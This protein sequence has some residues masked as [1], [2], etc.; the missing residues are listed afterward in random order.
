MTKLL[1]KAIAEIRKLRPERQ[2]DAAAMLF[3]IVEQEESNLRLSPEQ[4]DEVKL[5]LREADAGH[6][7]EPEEIEHLYRKYGG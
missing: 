3:T 4:L 7:V 5:S 1:E 2:E 6:F